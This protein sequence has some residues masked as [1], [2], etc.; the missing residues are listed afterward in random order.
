MATL[1]KPNGGEREVALM[2]MF[3]RVLTRARKYLIRS[4]DKEHAGFWDKAVAG[5]SALRAALWRRLADEA[6]VLLGT[7]T[8]STFLD[9]EKF[10]DSLDPCKVI[11][12]MEELNFPPM[13]LA[14]TLQVHWGA[15][16]LQA[17][18]C[19]GRP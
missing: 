9:V 5:S 1:P 18:G 4:W 19:C 14:I 15:R 13:L 2:C 16:I 17:R 6:A 3:V 11:S 8:L 12:S 10:H 7:N